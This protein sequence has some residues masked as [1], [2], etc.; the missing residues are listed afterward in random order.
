MVYQ[1][2]KVDQQA[3]PGRRPAR[4]RRRQAQKALA[5]YTVYLVLV[6]AVAFTVAASSVR[7]AKQGQELVALKEE[8]RRLEAD[9]KRMEAE[10]LGLQSLARIEREAVRLG[11]QRPKVVRPVP[12]VLATGTPVETLAEGKPA[13]NFE[14][15][16]AGAWS[17]PG[18][19]SMIVALDRLAEQVARWLAGS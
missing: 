11:L 7:V 8:F 5:H 9:N 17:G 2:G 16:Q 14:L 3:L 1:P 10:T 4:A 6:A 18:L 15:V 13:G 12:F 19:K